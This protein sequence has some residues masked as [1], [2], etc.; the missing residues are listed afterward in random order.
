MS[1]DVCKLIWL[2]LCLL[3]GCTGPGLEPP[4][5]DGISS[6]KGGPGIVGTGGAG[7]TADEGFSGGASG[8]GGTSV[9]SGGTGAPPAVS[10]GGD[11]GQQTGGD[12][13]LDLDGGVDATSDGGADHGTQELTGPSYMGSVDN[14]ADCAT[15]YPTRGYEPLGAAGERYP[16]FLYFVGTA[17]VAGD[18]SASYDSPAALAVTEAMA[19]RGFVAL[20]VQY[21]NGA[22]AW[23]SDHT[24]QLACLFD[25]S[26]PQ[27]LIAQACVLPNVDCDLGLATWGHSQG[28]Y[29][30]AMTY[31]FDARVRAVWTT[32]YGGDAATQLPLN[33]LRV[34]N[35]EA[36][37]SNGTAAKLM[38]ITGLTQTECPDPD[39][40]LRA[41]GS[42]WIIVRK[43]ELADP[44]TSSADHCWFDR[45]SC[46]ANT[47][48][49]EPN[50][51]DP[52]SDKPFALERN[53]DWVAGMVAAP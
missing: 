25:D 44:A 38:M 48:T 10:N 41:N 39:Q 12:G 16:L 29:V 31:N 49:L 26:K 42:G 24:G 1:C 40:C 50:W 28:A 32:G 7:G 15:S 11:V 17:F 30:A 27:S 20:S 18:A 35:G 3:V 37:S 5:S 53:A 21:D 13:V 14:G 45:P 36:D 2:P 47:I 9:T 6:G 33:R 51:I 23:L 52:N 43:S 22:V 46:S 4:N 19:R 34:V 8:A